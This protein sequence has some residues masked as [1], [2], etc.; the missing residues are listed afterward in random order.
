M[1]EIYLIGIAVF[2]FLLTLGAGYQHGK[3]GSTEVTVGMVLVAAVLWPLTLPFMIG[4][5]LGEKQK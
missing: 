3:L 4:G 1:L 5:Y 2:G